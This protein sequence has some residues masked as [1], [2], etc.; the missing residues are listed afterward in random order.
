[1]GWSSDKQSVPLV[2]RSYEGSCFRPWDVDTL[3]VLHSCIAIVQFLIFTP[4][5]EF[6]VDDNDGSWKTSR[7]PTIK[8]TKIRN[9]RH[10][11]VTLSITFS[12]PYLH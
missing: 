8:I 3:Y 11:N 2:S 6:A 7:K 9:P 1:M 4:N 5:N 12:F 10:R